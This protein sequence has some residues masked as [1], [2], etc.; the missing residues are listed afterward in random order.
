MKFNWTLVEFKSDELLLKLDFEHKNYVSSNSAADR[1]KVTIYGLDFFVDTRYNF[2]RVPT[3]LNLATLPPM[4]FESELADAVSTA[5]SV[6]STMS[7]TLIANTAVTFLL[8]G[9]L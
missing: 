6:Q 9:P 2:M 8:A 3:V 1:I 7:S 5:K 4:C